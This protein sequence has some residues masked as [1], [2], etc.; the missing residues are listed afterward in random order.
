MTLYIY[1]QFNNPCTVLGSANLIIPNPMLPNVSYKYTCSYI[2]IYIYIYL[3][4]F[5]F[6]GL[7]DASK[8]FP[9]HNFKCC[10]LIF[11][12]FFSLWWI[13]KAIWIATFL[14][15]PP[16]I[17][18][19]QKIRPSRLRYMGHKNRLTNKQIYIYIYPSLT[20]RF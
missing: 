15:V 11:R 20:H 8:P 5:I 1:I 6:T 12:I 9:G 10:V 13:S 3:H 14:W 17:W 7:L 19:N 2:Y 4:I 16:V 18:R